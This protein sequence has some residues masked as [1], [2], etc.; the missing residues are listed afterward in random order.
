MTVVNGTVRGWGAGLHVENGRG[1][2][3]DVTFDRIAGIGIAVIESDMTIEDTTVRRSDVGLTLFAYGSTTVARSRFIDNATA[4]TAAYSSVVTVEDSTLEGNAT[5]VECSDA[6]A[7]VARSRLA[8]NTTAVSF[9]WCE[10][11]GIQGS[12]LVRNGTAMR[13]EPANPSS[14]SQREGDQ[15]FG[16]RFDR[17]DVAL[18]LGVN[19]HLQ[20]NVFTRNGTA[21]RALTAG[22]LLEVGLFALERNTFN[23]NGDAVDVD[24]KIRMRDNVAT[25]NTGW[26]IHTPAAEDLGGNVAWGNGREPQCVGVVCT[27]RPRS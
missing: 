1:A 18:D 22:G 26:G 10:G 12:E 6:M 8:R 27:G 13:T 25:R 19:A 16:N 7:Y 5:A 14:G 17:N 9:F 21:F 3:R 15:I 23:R 20:D 4:V 2:V 24:T 11:S